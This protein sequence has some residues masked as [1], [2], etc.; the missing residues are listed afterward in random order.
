MMWRSN[1]DGDYFCIGVSVAKYLE[2]S[3]L[4]WNGYLGIVVPKRKAKMPGR[5]GD[6]E[7]AIGERVA[8]RFNDV[9]QRIR[10]AGGGVGEQTRPF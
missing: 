8:P 9:E 4:K 2:R 7:R 5:A 1:Q 3:C 6:F 10:K